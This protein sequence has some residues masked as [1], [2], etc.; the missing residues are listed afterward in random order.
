MKILPAQFPITNLRS[1]VWK[2][3]IC[4][5][6]KTGERLVDFPEGIIN[7][8]YHSKTHPE[9][10]FLKYNEEFYVIKCIP[11]ILALNKYFNTNINGSHKHIY[12][13][14]VKRLIHDLNFIFGDLICS[15]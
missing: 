2:L 11:F 1:I 5:Q 4:H 14:D 15:K 12:V 8:Y 3:L 10:I 7:F 6:I 9:L 13:I